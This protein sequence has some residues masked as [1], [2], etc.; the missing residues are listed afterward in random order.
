MFCL[1][2]C[3]LLLVE[4][5][6]NLIALLTAFTLGHAASSALAMMGWL[7][8][9]SAFIELMIGLTIIGAA[10]GRE[11]TYALLEAVAPMKELAV[12]EGLGR[13]V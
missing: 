5:A 4:R 13:L 3:L 12:R 2:L 11:F 7:S 8:S 1:L 6:R 9:E 10:L